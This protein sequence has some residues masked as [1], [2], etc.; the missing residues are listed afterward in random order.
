MMFSSKI[1]SSSSLEEDYTDSIEEED[2]EEQSEEMEKPLNLHDELM[3]V[4]ETIHRANELFEKMSYEMD[5]KQNSNKII[6]LLKEK[7]V[8]KENIILSL[9]KKVESFMENPD[10]IKQTQDLNMTLLGYVQTLKEENKKLQEEN[11]R[12]RESAAASESKHSDGRIAELE[13]ELT[14]ST[15]HRDALQKQ[16]EGALATI[17]SLKQQNARLQAQLAESGSDAELER[18]RMRAAAVQRAIGSGYQMLNGEEDSEEEDLAEKVA[19]LEKMNANMREKLEA[20]NAALAN[21]RA[22]VNI[23]YKAVAEAKVAAYEQA[24]EENERLSAEVE[25]LKQSEHDLS[26]EVGELRRR[27][28]RTGELLRQYVERANTAEKKLRESGLM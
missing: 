16:F 18:A 25:R 12:L 2:S 6:A 21:S 11:K 10:H 17:D 1:G 13:E 27:P 22:G 20:A 7:I 23:D 15:T 28:D 4:K 9:K 14:T 19:V 24:L 8:Q 3:D 5:N 26:V